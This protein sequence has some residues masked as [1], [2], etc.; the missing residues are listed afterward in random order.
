MSNYH[1]ASNHITLQK[2]QP[3]LRAH[4]RSTVDAR[5]D[6]LKLLCDRE[7]AAHI[8]CFIDRVFAQPDVRLREYFKIDFRSIAEMTRPG[9]LEGIVKD[10]PKLDTNKL[11]KDYG[12]V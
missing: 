9:S 12:N 7:S 10:Y 5:I 11:L 6:L 2:W 1:P 8:D 3:F 4:P